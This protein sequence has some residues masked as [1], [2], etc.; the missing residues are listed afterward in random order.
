MCRV[1]CLANCDNKKYFIYHTDIYQGRNIANIDIPQEIIH[2]KSTQKAVINALIKADITNDP[3][4][5]WENYCD[6][7]HQSPEAS[8]YA[9]EKLGILQC[10]SGTCYWMEQRGH[11]PCEVISAWIRHRTLQQGKQRHDCCMESQQG[12]QCGLDFEYFWENNYSMSH[13]Q[14]SSTFSCQKM[15][16]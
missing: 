2:L 10:G 11:V 4:G 16:Q 3:D 8:V 1:F 12:R 7:R 13:W 15:Y 6:S 14:R 9:R 5:V